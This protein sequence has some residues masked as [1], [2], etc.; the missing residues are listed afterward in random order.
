V[1]GRHLTA[2]GTDGAVKSARRGSVAGVRP[3]GHIRLAMTV[4]LLSSSRFGMLAERA[5]ERAAEFSPDALAAIVFSALWVEAFVNELI[6]RVTVGRED[7][8]PEAVRRLRQRAI[9]ADLDGRDARLDVKVQVIATGLT[10]SPFDIG[11][12]PYQDFH[13]LTGLRND[14]VHH[15]PETVKRGLRR[16]RRLTPHHSGSLSLTDQKFGVKRGHRRT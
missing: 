2:T 10:G 13:L 7:I 1:K 4:F 9:A 12:Q 16:I 8:L 5:V 11:L 15:R 6:H 3:M 14:L